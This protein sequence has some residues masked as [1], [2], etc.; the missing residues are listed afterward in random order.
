MLTI[1]FFDGNMLTVINKNQNK[2]YDNKS[3][4]NKIVIM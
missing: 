4:G 2:M 3:L 1:F